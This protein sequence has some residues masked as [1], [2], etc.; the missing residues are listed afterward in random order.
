MNVVEIYSKTWCGYC[1]LAEE[2]LSRKGVEYRVVDITHDTPGQIEMVRRSGR[3]SVPQ[4][5]IGGRHFGGS[6]ELL[7]AETNGQLNGLLSTTGAET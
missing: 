4:I 6:D 3:K 7:A 1:A 2:L 5:F